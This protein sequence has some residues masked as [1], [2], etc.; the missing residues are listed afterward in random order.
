[1]SSILTNNGAMTALQSLKSINMNLA[2]TQEMIST[3]KSVGS[4]KDNSALWAISKVMESDVA[5]FKAIS[6]SLALGESTVAVARQAAESVTDL[7]TEIKGKIVNSQESNVD[8]SQL[9]TEITAL[10]DQIKSIVGA[11]QFNGLNL[12]NGSQTGTNAGGNVGVDILSSLDR[13]GTGVTSKQIGVDAQNLSTTAG[14]ALTGSATFG[15]IAGGS[16][17]DS[18]AGTAT[19][20]VADGTATTDTVTITD[21]D[22]L[23]AAGAADGTEALK[24]TAEGVDTTL[25]TGL[26]EGDSLS[27][28]V[29]NN[30]GTYRVAA[31]DTQESVVA[32]LNSAL[33][34]AGV[35]DSEITLD[36]DT[37][38]GTLSITNETN[39]EVAISF[40]MT[41]GSGALAGIDNISVTDDAGAAAALDTIETMIQSSINAAANFG[42]VEKRIE[43]QGDFISKLTDSLKSGIG[44]L[45]DADM[46]AASARLQALQVQQQLGVQALSIANQAPQSILSLFR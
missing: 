17:A 11:A 6:G 14:T 31:G 32:G 39:S 42:S 43:I 1:M 22:F 38:A 9:Q 10:T 4:A 5:G 45:V 2:K 24:S 12:V 15:T 36:I 21:F 44:S 35:S 20:G 37:A 40:S 29:G 18:A 7:L 41:R 28:K 16:A 23:T 27:I 30:V 34:S 33:R 26:V 19:L 13:N 46:E 25:A 8:R 3:G